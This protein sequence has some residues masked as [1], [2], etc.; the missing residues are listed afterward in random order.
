MRR[1]WDVIRKVL[2]EVEDLDPAERD[3]KIYETGSGEI[4]EKIKAEHAV[5]LWQAGFLSGID[6]STVSDGALMSPEL[7]WAGHDLL[8]TMRSATVWERIK[9]IAKD[10]G[11][12]L[13]FD[14]VKAL[15]KV[16]LESAIGN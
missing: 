5:L 1:D 12:E 11:I 3:R 8:Q 4:E 9:T 10:R 2:S 15:G 14:A 7:T 13:T 16:A 6:V